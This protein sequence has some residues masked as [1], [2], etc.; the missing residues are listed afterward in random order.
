M[1]GF[2][3]RWKTCTRT[4][5]QAREIPLPEP[6][7]HRVPAWLAAR[8]PDAASAGDWDLW[9]AYGRRV[10]ATASVALAVGLGLMWWGPRENESLRPR[11]ETSMAQAIWL[12]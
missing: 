10:L 11:I 4:A 3:E 7:L 9:W 6:P 1:S 8:T 2:D 5:R 12:R